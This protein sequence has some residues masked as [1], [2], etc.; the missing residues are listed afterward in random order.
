MKSSILILASGLALAGCQSLGV[1]DCRAIDWYQLGVRDG[2]S[3]SNLI[4]RYT[5]QCNSSGAQPDAARYAEGRVRGLWVRQKDHLLY[6][7]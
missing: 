4:D 3:N 1:G 7:P 5:A 2:E 6:T